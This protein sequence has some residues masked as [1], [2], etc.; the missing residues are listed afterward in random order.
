MNISS[1]QLAFVAVLG[2]SSFF[3]GCRA[4]PTPTHEEHHELNL[5]PVTASVA[6]RLD[7]KTVNVDV[8]AVAADAGSI[9]L[10][11][12]W[13]AAFPTTDASSLHFDLVGSDGFRPMSRPKCT[14]LLSSDELTHFRLDAVKHDVSIGDGLELPGC[15]RVH[16]VVAIEA[17]R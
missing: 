11:Q 8:S 7:G 1:R 12:I 17:T 4:K 9:P 15:Y 10:L 5:P 2:A 3:T 16:A 14:H 6:V 13:G